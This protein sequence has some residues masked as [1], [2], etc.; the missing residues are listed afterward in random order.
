MLL[1]VISGQPSSPDGSRSAADSLLPIVQSQRERYRVRA[2]ELEA[3]SIVYY[4]IASLNTKSLLTYGPLS[5][6]Q[7]LIS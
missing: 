4:V 2:Q 7:T 6:S 5:M 3:V 1:I